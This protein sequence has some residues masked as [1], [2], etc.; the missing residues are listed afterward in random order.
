MSGIAIISS[1][2]IWAVGGQDILHWDGAGWSQS[3]SPRYLRNVVSISSKNIYAVGE[4]AILH[5]GGQSWSIVAEPAQYL[6]SISAVSATNVWTRGLARGIILHGTSVVRPQLT[7]PPNH[8][9]LS[10]STPT[11]RWENQSCAAQYKVLLKRD[12]RDGRKVVRTTVTD[13]KYT[14]PLLD[15][16][17]HYFWRVRVCDKTQ[18][19]SKW[20]KWREFYALP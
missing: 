11:V 7:A 2:D 13:N 4:R 19:C 8:Q 3:L 18:Y 12:A 5:W 6:M 14:T 9:L 1:N 20:S 17:H 15:A 10:N 16:Y